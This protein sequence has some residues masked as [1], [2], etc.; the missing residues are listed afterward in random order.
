MMK[1]DFVTVLYPEFI[2][3]LVPGSYS[4]NMWSSVP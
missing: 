3:L 1:S 4:T 2:S